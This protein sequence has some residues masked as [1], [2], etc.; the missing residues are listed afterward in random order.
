M[1]WP[2]F[3]AFNALGAALWVG[4]WAS[5]GY[6][7]GDHIQTIYDGVTRYSLYGLIA[8]AVVVVALIVRAVL[9]RRRRS[10]AGGRAR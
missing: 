2:R 3:L 10:S 9:R 4:V 6:L 8:L 1:P 5:V 7:A